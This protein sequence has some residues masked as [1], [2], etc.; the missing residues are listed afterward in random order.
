MKARSWAGVCVRVLLVAMLGVLP[1]VAATCNDGSLIVNL[2]GG[3]GGHDCDDD[4]CGGGWGWF[5]YDPGY[6][7][8]C[9]WW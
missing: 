5:G 4:D 3:W 6:C 2:P 1:Q 9:G 8:D 7:Y